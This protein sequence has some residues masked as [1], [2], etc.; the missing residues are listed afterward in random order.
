MDSRSILP[1]D[2]AISELLESHSWEGGLK[3]HA[4]KEPKREKRLGPPSKK[5]RIRVN[6]RGSQEV[7]QKY[8]FSVVHTR[9]EDK[10]ERQIHYG[11]YPQFC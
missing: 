3:R 5:V 6:I 11:R 4:K 9:Q 2:T 8:L 10:Q 1:F 7:H